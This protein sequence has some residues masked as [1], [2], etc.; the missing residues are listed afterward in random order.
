MV[1]TM[2]TGTRD[3]EESDHGVIQRAVHDELAEVQPEQFL[4]GGAQGSDSVA[5]KSAGTLKDQFGYDTELV[6]IVPWTLEDQPDDAIPVIEEY[7]DRVIEMNHDSPVGSAPGYHA[8]NDELIDRADRCRGF[9][10]GES[11][12]TESTLEKADENG[13]H[14][15]EH[16]LG[17]YGHT[18]AGAVL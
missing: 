2:M 14:I 18:T 6:V 16:P 15:R 10:D 1:V 3:I 9:W 13:L 7:A 5:L 12:G 17:D 11:S 8:R 4:F